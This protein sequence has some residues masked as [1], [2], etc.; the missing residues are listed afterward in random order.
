MIAM[1]RWVKVKGY[2]LYEI[3]DMGRLKTYNWK[4]QGIERIMRPALDGSGY[5]RTM[6]KSD[7]GRVHTVKIHRLV[8]ISFI[9]DPLPGQECNH[10]NGIRTDNRLINLEWI[11]HA[12][13]IKHSFI[14]GRSNNQGEN[15]P[16]ATITENEVREIRLNYQYGKKRKCG[17]TKQQIADQYGVSFHV[18]KRIVSGKTWKHLL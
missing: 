11:S 1:E 15:N 12:E 14:I 5:L 6:L 17:I 13:N 3:S 8:L 7:S 18:I 4:N 9:G 10:K 2:S 16:A